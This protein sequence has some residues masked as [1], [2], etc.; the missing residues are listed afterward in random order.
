MKEQ[1]IKIMEAFFDA[2]DIQEITTIQSGLINNTYKITTNKGDFIV[3][4]LNQNVFKNSSALLENKIKICHFLET[5]QFPTITYLR[6]REGLFYVKEGEDIWQLSNYI[7]STIKDRIDS[8]EVAEKAGKHLAQFHEAL[9]DFPVDELEYTIP[10]FHN[11]CKRYADFLENV[12]QANADR[13]I[14]AKDEIE[15]IHLF[16]PKIEKVAKAIQEGK[17]P[18]RVVHND[19]KISN[20]L[21]DEFGSIICLIDFDT[22]MPGSILHDIG[23]AMRSGANTATEE[24][25]ELAKVNFN[26][27]IYEAFMKAYLAIARGFLTKEE[28][29][30][31][32]LSL[33]LLLFEQSCRFLADFLINDPYYS[34][35][36]ELQNLV[37]TKTQLKLLEQ[38]GAY[39]KL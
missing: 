5:K 30:N 31:I 21:F 17:I 14:L 10:D 18:L 24:E 34:T 33:P 25:K 36:Y 23:D 8:T 9:L 26:H 7:P 1:L 2:I 3:Q 12:A 28:L 16:Y 22:L 38:V 27:T 39:F 37:R 29:E 19:T 11:T 32:H 35:Q 15:K 20:M 13:L 6:S 4:Q